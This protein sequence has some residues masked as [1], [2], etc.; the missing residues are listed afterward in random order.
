M[1]NSPMSCFFRASRCRRLAIRQ[2]LV[3]ALVSGASLIFAAAKASA[4]DAEKTHTAAT[5]ESAPAPE[6]SHPNPLEF[7]TDLALWTFVIFVVLFIV[8]KKFAWGP[9]SQSLEK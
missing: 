9:I 8:L 7:K 1:R 4:Q 2:W 3:V 5:A 6:E